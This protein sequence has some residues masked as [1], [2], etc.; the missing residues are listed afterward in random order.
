MRPESGAAPKP[1]AGRRGQAHAIGPGFR[2]LV[3]RT[4]LLN[5]GIFLSVLVMGMLGGDA[6]ALGLVLL[7]TTAILWCATFAIAPFFWLGQVYWRRRE[8][9]RKQPPLHA[10]GAGG[11]RDEWLDAM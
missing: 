7:V 4:L 3:H 6:S 11:I 9:H 8:L 10:I 5:L 2:G 1:V